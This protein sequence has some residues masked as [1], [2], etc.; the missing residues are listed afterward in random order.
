MELGTLIARLERE[1][2]AADATGVLVW[3]D[4]LALFAA[5]EAMGAR[6]DETPAAYLANAARRFA[7]LASDEEWLALTGALARTDDP[8]LTALGQMVR[9]ALARDQAEQHGTA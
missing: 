1:S 8:A 3:L 6:Y 4:D 2:D 9:W 7:R 5:V